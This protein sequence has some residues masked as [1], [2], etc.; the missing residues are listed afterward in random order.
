MG[1]NN[2]MK[3]FSFVIPCY[4][5]EKSIEMV[6]NLIKSTMAQNI[7]E[8]EIIL[9]N[10]HSPD[11]VWEIIK[12][13]A[14]NDDLITGIDLARN[15]GQ[16]S[17]L[18]AGYAVAEGDIVISLDDDGQ[19]PVDEVG[20][21]LDAIDE[22]YDVV[23]AEYDSIKQSGFRIFGSKVNEKMTEY[24]IGKPKEIRPT[25]YFAAKRFVVDE[26]L[27]YK[28]A[29][30]YVGGLIFRTTKN[31]ANVKVHHRERIYGT[32]GYNFIKLLSLWING[33]TAFSVKPLRLATAAGVICSVCG[34]SYGIYTII[35]KLINPAITMGYSSLLTSI[36]FVG[37]V[38]MLLLGMI[39]EYV[40]RIYLCLNNAPQ[41]VIREIV[42]KKETGKVLDR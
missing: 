30:P 31:I 21:L 16:H 4:R 33:F 11:N 22:G 9:V 32:S 6:V 2:I 35:R 40:G 25:S 29:Y 5:S 26:M 41:Y 7:G 42:S 12:H 18:M 19:T 28:H 23:F 3:K 20:K 27:K 8:Y 36:L 24:L 14:E 15:F 10:D 38:I 37:G 13:M 17:A 39:G 1:G 34:F